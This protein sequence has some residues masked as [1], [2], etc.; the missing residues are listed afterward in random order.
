LRICRCMR[1]MSMI[2]CTT[3]ARISCEHVAEQAGA[4]PGAP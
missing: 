2:L 3:I 4:G 1:S